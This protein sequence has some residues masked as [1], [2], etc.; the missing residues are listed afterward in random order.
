[1]APLDQ[2]GVVNSIGRV[3]G[4]QNLIVADNSVNPA[5]MDGT[6]MATGYL[7]AANIAQLLLE[8]N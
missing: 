1:M 6:P 8:G 7:V 2:G 5:G 4:V 3:Y